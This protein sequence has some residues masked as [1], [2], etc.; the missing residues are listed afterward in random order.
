MADD[1]PWRVDVRFAA[2][3]P[4]VR[5]N[6]LLVLVRS[7]VLSVVVGDDLAD[8]QPAGTAALITVGGL[9]CG[10][11]DVHRVADAA[12]HWLRTMPGTGQQRVAMR[13]PHRGAVWWIEP[14]GA[15]PAQNVP[16]VLRSRSEAAARERTTILVL[17]D[18]WLPLRGGLS[19][20]NRY[21]CIALVHAG[22]QVYCA[23]PAFSIDEV[24][25]AASSGVN[26]VTAPQTTDAG[27][28]PRSRPELPDG[29][30]P[31]AVVGHGRITGP[32]AVS[33]VHDHFRTAVRLHIVH[34]EPDEVA[35]HKLD[36]DED[37]GRTAEERTAAELA[38]CAG[39]RVI[40][41]GPRLHQWL[42]RDLRNVNGVPP[43]RLDPGF[44]TYGQATRDPLPGIP[45]VL[46]LGR[47]GDHMVKG[48]DIAARAVGHA[49]ELRGPAAGSV[50]LLIRGAYEHQGADLRAVI[51]RMINQPTVRVLPRNY[52]VDFERIRQDLTRASLM[53]MPSR[54]EGFG[55]VGLEAIVLGVPAL[56]SDRSGLGMLLREVLPREL[57]HQIVVPVEDDAERDTA[58]WGHA[59]A[60]ILR[61]RRAAFDTAA[62]V[63]AIMA[64]ERTWAMA[65]DVVLTAI[66][67]TRSANVAWPS[68]GG[69]R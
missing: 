11:D 45:Q 49:V 10:P 18:E 25:D 35:W 20:L 43:L 62:A 57:V 14:T 40:A 28:A 56:V 53:L 27:E 16:P 66:R 52:S 5:R 42:D 37:V 60:A 2:T 65:A 24:A 63:M 15:L 51:R 58:V 12:R 39:A 61:N 9:R 47:M 50:D 30:V 31:D 69:V 33:Q 6:E 1:E 4:V 64:R 26:L 23:V 38:L 54:A 7:I 29:V 36:P 59:V 22:A 44:G 41:V 8:D 13:T 68:G 55:L 48:L 19:A 34:S 21:L 3:V 67:P 32:M 17:A 46:I